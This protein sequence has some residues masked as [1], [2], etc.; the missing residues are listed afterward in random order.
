MLRRVVLGAATV[1]ACVAP[2]HGQLRQ[3][4]EKE[5]FTFGTCGQP[6]CLDASQLI[7]HG[8]HFIPATQ[9]GG[10]NLISFL[11]TAI[12][13]SVSNTPI[14][15]ASSGTTFKFEGGLPVKTSTSAGPIFAERAQTLGRGRWFVGLGVSAMNFERLRGVPLRDI[16]LNFTHQDVP[17]L[18]TLGN[19]IFE[20]DFINVKVAM[21]VSLLVTSFSL[22]YG[23]V[24]GVDLSV[25][26]PFVRTSVQGHSIAQIVPVSG[27]NLHY[28]AGTQTNPVLTAVASTDGAASGLGD[29]TGRLKINVA[30][31]NKIGVAILGEARFPTGDENN[32]LG[33]GAFSGRGL[34]IISAA[35]GDFNPH[36]NFGV[37]VRDAKQQNN[38]IDANLGFDDLLAPWSTM[39]FDVLGSWQVG[40]SKL[41]VPPPVLYTYPS[42]RTLDVTNIP[43]Q[44]DDYMSIAIGFKFAT[45]R[46]I[47]IVTNALF[48]IRD[49]GLQPSVAWT[50]GLEY[51]F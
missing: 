19:P 26:V 39:V 30:Q 49:S 27:T 34:G 35:F 32:L 3:Q 40:D 41:D 17:P 18:D 46:G 15:S 6:L 1:L 12:G 25:A 31:T 42:V 14:S 5:L 20:N 13:I 48:P 44:R 51:N 50:A 8:D 28:F 7:G 33:S 11:S 10:A 47:Q 4:I 36:L 9:S 24:D 37:T 21:D 29:V 23:L 16:Q 45:R 43:S 38:S 2:L 22:S